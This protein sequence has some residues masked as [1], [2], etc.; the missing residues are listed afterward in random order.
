MKIVFLDIDG[1]L[2]NTKILK[3]RLDARSTLRFG[4]FDPE[5]VRC[6]NELVDRADAQIVLSSS[7]R[8][9]PGPEYWAALCQHLKGQGVGRPLVGRTPH[10]YECGS[11]GYR[12]REIQWWV[13]HNGPVD[14]FVILD[15]DSD[16]EPYMD[17][18]VKTDWNQG[19]RQHHIVDALKILGVG[20]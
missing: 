17:R 4:P 16:M 19:L 7:W 12:G 13:E 14:A 20:G 11:N 10:S 5:S 15:D 1:V 2:N 3:Q 6:L 9:G 18:F 8:N